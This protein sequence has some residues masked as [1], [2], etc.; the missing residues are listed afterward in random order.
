MQQI[1]L[2]SIES[3]GRMEAQNKRILCRLR[4]PIILHVHR[5]RRLATQPR[6]SF[7]ALPTFTFV[8]SCGAPQPTG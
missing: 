8:V 4:L 1:W 7:S 5:S 2:R 3:G 6:T